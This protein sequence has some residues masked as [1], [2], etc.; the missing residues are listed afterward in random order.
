VEREEFVNAGVV[1]YCRALG[2][3]DARIALDRARVRALFP[4]PSLDL[5]T[6][7]RGLSL[8]P[9]LCTGDPSAGPIAALDQ[10]ERF[11][12]LCATRSTVNQLSP[13]HAGLCDD[14]AITLDHLMRTMVG[15]PAAA[16]P[17][18][19]ERS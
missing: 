18:S 2:Y 12:W 17:A 13:V 10:A 15:A 1:L 16:T 14:P 9:R 11:R 6:I 8:I 7:E 19:D 5:E 4:D 3:L